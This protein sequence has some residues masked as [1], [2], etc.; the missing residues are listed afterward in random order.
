MSQVGFVFQLEPLS[1][2]VQLVQTRT[3]YRHAGQSWIHCVLFVAMPRALSSRASPARVS[4][5]YTSNAPRK[6]S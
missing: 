2:L 5:Q 6:M 1:V 4:R 3:R